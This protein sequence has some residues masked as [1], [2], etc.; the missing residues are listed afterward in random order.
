MSSAIRLAEAHDGD[1][2]AAIYHP[3]VVSAVTSFE[4]EAPNGK[5]MSNRVAA[6]LP[7]APWIVAEQ[8]GVVLG[9]AY[10]SKHH[11]RAA[12]QWSVDV[13]VYI[14]RAHHRRGV[15]KALYTS[16]FAMLRMQGFYNAYAG[17]TLP[18]PASVGLHESFGFQPVGVYHSVGFKFGAWHDVGWWQMALRERRGDPV[19]PLSFAEA[20]ALP[21]WDAALRAG[22]NLL[23]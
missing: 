14:D 3:S 13:S 12:Y 16:L 7:Y 10:A 2:I 18:N 20:R 19:A 4:V 23:R 15:G 17:I 11:E 8:D 9:Y 21:G 5:D 6:L 22:L 1:A